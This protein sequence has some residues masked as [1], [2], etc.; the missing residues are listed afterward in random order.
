ML[1]FPEGEWSLHSPFF[2]D[3]PAEYSYFPS[4][5]YNPYSLRPN[6]QHYELTGGYQNIYHFFAER[7]DSYCVMMYNK[8]L[9][10]WFFVFQNYEYRRIISMKR[11]KQIVA[12]CVVLL[13]V[14]GSVSANVTL[15]FRAISNNSGI[16]AAL[17]P[18]FALDVSDTTDGNILFRLWNHVGIPCSIT[19]VYFENPESV[20]TLPGDITNSAG[21]NFTSPTNPGNLPEGNTIGFQTDPFGA[22][23]QGKPKTGIDATDEYVDI[24]FGLN[25]TYANVE[26]KLLAA[27]MRI[28]IHVQSING[29]TSDS[30][31]TMTPPP[32]VP[33]PAAVA[34]GSIGIALVGWLRRR[35]AI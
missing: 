8:I 28:G 31:V 12:V 29:D 11:V 25:T 5:H 27:S 16:S 3:L 15:S 18:Q 33:A 22:G 32:S 34:L 17:A 2:R 10:M 19:K 23:T 30:F 9:K 1:S 35:N 21:V 4:V 20:L 26:A 13:T 14:A 7:K 6:H 24:R